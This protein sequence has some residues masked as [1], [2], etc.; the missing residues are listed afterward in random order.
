MTKR[1]PDTRRAEINMMN[2]DA[3]VF[4]RSETI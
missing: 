2:F 1:H 3:G 4:T